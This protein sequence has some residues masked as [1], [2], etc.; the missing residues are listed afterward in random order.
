VGWIWEGLR[1]VLMCRWVVIVGSTAGQDSWGYQRLLM[2]Y[3]PHYPSSFCP[4][5]RCTACCAMLCVQLQHASEIAQ[6]TELEQWLME[7]AYNKVGACCALG[8]L[9]LSASVTLLCSNA[10]G[11]V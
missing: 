10:T 1:L 7:G 9:V 2:D 8:V 6:V 5:P 3:L 11:L 4:A